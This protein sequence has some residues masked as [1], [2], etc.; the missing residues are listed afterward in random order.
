MKKIILIIIFIGGGLSITA[1]QKE[2][3]VTNLLAEIL[4]FLK[5][6]ITIDFANNELTISGEKEI[7][8][9][10]AE[11]DLQC[12]REPSAL[13]ERVCYQE[14]KSINGIP[15]NTVA[16]FF[17]DDTLT[18]IAAVLP[19]SSQ[20]KIVEHLNQEYV[21]FNKE[22]SGGS[23]KKSMAVWVTV[24]GIIS[25][26]P[27]TDPPPKDARMIW[28]SYAALSK[29]QSSLAIEMMK[30]KARAKPDD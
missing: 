29:K 11:L 28:T 18:S 30:L 15:A 21:L 16:F 13:G 8:E 20:L 26:H 17:I 22:Y 2:T 7:L 12:A 5:P 14:I 1:S 10:Y 24:S 23:D 19:S 9:D 25:A 27:G 6:G 4:P 3:N